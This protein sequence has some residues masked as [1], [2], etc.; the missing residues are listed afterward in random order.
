MKGKTRQIAVLVFGMFFLTLGFSIIMP[1]LPYYTQK[2]G[3][4]ALDLGLLM[5]SYSV[6]QFIVTPFWGEMS[7]RV[8]RKPIFLIGLFG[9]G[10]S[11]I[12]YGF[13]TQLWMLF[14]ARMLGGALAGGMYPASLAYIADVTEHSERGQVMGLLGA[15]SGLGMIFGPS[16]SGIL[17]V[18]G[19]TVPFS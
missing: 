16:I 13:A 5:A 6:M 1:I 14:A 19:L 2:M 12:V 3:A 9:Y 17:S 7:D 11:F 18:W 4:S 8:G 15:A 10:V